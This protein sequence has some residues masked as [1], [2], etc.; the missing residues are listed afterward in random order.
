MSTET[1]QYAAEEAAVEQIRAAREQI[2]SELSKAVIG[3]QEVIEQL[4]LCLFAGG[5][6]LITG[7]PG[8]AKTLL[9][10]SISQIFDLEFR[11]IQFTPDLMPADI[12][13]TE[14]LEETHDGKR[15]LQF[16]KGP[17]FANVILADEINRTPP[18][19]QA[20]LLEAMQEHQVTAAGVRYPL[21]KPFFVLA[22]QNPIEMEGT[23]PLPEAQLDRF[24]FNIWMDYLP[25][26]DEVAVV[27]QTT[28]RSNQPIQS[29]FSGEDVLRFHQVVKKAPIAENLVRYAV[30]LADASRPGRPS[31][32]DFVNQWVTW[33]AGLR[34]AQYL[35][36]GAKARA[37][38]QGRPHVV[39]DDVKALAHVTLRH[40]ILVGYRAEAEGI[41]VE[42]VVDQLLK[43]IAVPGA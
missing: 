38:L 15:K 7:A 23:Y 29:L 1:D 31:T 10:N 39:A 2:F 16:A 24:M 13:G 26:D 27:S 20:A 33:G 21:E 22:T 36:L 43:T 11:R 19:T 14:I 37:L 28:S 32:P 5:H 35:V 40:R 4:L 3:Q 30:R 25:E 42:K 12:T 18:K 8:L 41:T 6:C 9:V 17:I 34:A